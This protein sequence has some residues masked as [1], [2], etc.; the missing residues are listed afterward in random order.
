MVAGNERV[1]AEW[2]QRWGREWPEAS[3]RRALKFEAFWAKAKVKLAE[4]LADR[5]N[6]GDACRK[7]G[8]DGLLN[9]R[10]VRLGVIAAASMLFAQMGGDGSEP[11]QPRIGD[12]Y[13]LWH[14]ILA[15]SADLFVTHD[16]R[17]AKALNRV[18]VTGFRAIHVRRG[19]RGQ[20]AS[21]LAV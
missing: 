12:A 6:L 13:D 18:P 2:E 1:Q 7:R 10:A 19:V 20:L 17:L 3:E 16:E 11:R 5:I 9:I 8:L 4:N 15:S 14:A 21:A